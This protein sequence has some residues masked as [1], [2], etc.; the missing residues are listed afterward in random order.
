MALT[1]QL[2][3]NKQLAQSR[4]RTAELAAACGRSAWTKTSVKNQQT[5]PQTRPVTGARAMVLARA[6]TAAWRRR[7][8]DVFAVEWYSSDS[9]GSEE[10]AVLQQQDAWGDSG[11]EWWLE[12]H[13][14]DLSAAGNDLTN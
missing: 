10:E 3:I 14:G 4:A 6:G 7:F 2:S 13:G 12:V 9:S 1:P 8:E 11:L 5:H